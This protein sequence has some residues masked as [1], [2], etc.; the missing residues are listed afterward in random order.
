MS[1]P[2]S[3]VDREL[4]GEVPV[5]NGADSTMAEAHGGPDHSDLNDSSGAQFN[6]LN[7]IGGTLV[8]A[9]SNGDDLEAGNVS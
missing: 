9:D 7:A 3:E 5:N 8:Q 6:P 1:S 2:L 4:L